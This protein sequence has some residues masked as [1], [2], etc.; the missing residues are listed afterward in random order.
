MMSADNTK[1]PTTR[2]EPA[3][4]IECELP[5]D[6]TDIKIMHQL[7]KEKNVTRAVSTACRGVD[8][9]QTAKTRLGKLPQAALYQVLTIIVTEAE[10][11][12]VFDFVCNKAQIGQPGRGTVFQSKLLGATRYVMPDDVPEEE[13][14]L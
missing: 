7:R 6:G 13:Y 4:M 3:T 11:S 5:D 8:N 2:L 14:E 10:A 12:D 1:S 9:L